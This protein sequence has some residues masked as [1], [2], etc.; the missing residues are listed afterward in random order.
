MSAGCG[1]RKHRAGGYTLAELLIVV[2]IIA[3]LAAVSFPALIHMRNSLRQTE[4]DDRAKEIFT[5]AQNQMSGLKLCG[6]LPVPQ[7][8]GS[9]GQKMD[10]SMVP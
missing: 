9:D 7:P 8:E 6:K 3:I 10:E 1:G 2:G 5:V 4:L